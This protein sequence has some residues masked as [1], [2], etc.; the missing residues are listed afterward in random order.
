LVRKRASR[1][2][3]R[4]GEDGAGDEP[5]EQHAD[6]GEVLRRITNLAVQKVQPQTHKDALRD[7]K[8]EKTA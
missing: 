1:L 6:G 7:A 3:N 5:I 8:F 2:S 4:A